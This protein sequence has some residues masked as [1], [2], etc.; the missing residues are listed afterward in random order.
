MQVLRNRTDSRR[1]HVHRQNRLVQSAVS[2]QPHLHTCSPAPSNGRIT[3]GLGRYCKAGV[4]LPTTD[5]CVPDDC[6]QLSDGG[7][8]A[9]GN[10]LRGPWAAAAHGSYV[11]VHFFF[12][13]VCYVFAYLYLRLPKH[14]LS[15]I[16]VSSHFI[17]CR[18]ATLSCSSAAGL[19]GGWNGSDIPHFV[20]TVSRKCHAGSFALPN[21]SCTF[22]SQALCTVIC[23][24]SRG[25]SPPGNACQRVSS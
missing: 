24:R 20:G 19:D 16:T 1:R 12:C 5:S 18:Y 7:F 10:P 13:F 4:L 15:Q 21:A 3:L 17:V 22:P 2:V 9:D 25:C 11:R 6:V 14:H 8:D 23:K